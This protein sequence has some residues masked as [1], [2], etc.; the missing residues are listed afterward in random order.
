MPRSSGELMVTYPTTV[1]CQEAECA[2]THRA[3][4]E[5]DATLAW[6]MH[7]EAGD[8]P[9]LD[10]PQPPAEPVEPTDQPQFDE[11]ADPGP[12]DPIGT[13]RATDGYLAIRAPSSSFNLDIDDE[14]LSWF[15]IDVGATHQAAEWLNGLEWEE[16][17][18]LLG[19]WSIV[20]QP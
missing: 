6:Q 15:V 18:E 16:I 19:T 3:Q 10:A 13:V 7:T 20:Y 8:C 1:K 2:W 5:D 14:G 4:D 9:Q 17:A 11:D 12:D